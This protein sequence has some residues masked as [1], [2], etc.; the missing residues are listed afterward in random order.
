MKGNCI[1]KINIGYK[2]KFIRNVKVKIKKI[3]LD[4]F[5]K[6]MDLILD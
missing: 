4:G 1:Y 5:N 3:L 2:K 6:R